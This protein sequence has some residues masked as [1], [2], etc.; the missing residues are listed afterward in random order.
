MKKASFLLVLLLYG[1]NVF[2]DCI[3]AISFWPSGQSIKQNSIILIE[4][5]GQS[6]E[7]VQALNKKYPVYLKTGNKKV[8]L[9]VREI[10]VG[11][12]NLTQAVLTVNEQLIIGQEY[13]LFIDGLPEFATP[14]TR[15]NSATKKN[16]VVK[17]IVEKNS[18]VEK[19][20]WIAKPSEIRKTLFFW[21]CGPEAN[22][23]FKFEITD[24]SEF[25]IKTTVSNIE[26]KKSTTCYV[27]PSDSSTFAVGRDMC[28]GAFT[29]DGIGN[30]EATFDIVDA[31]GNITVW[32]DRKIVFT[33]P[34]ETTT[35]D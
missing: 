4:G 2:A 19:P 13:E 12:Y 35:E 30:F 16:D 17:W 24:K 9:K 8:K 3:S 6:R 7:I 21:G 27:I 11:E 1:A 26:T 29:F 5:F 31:S 22:I 23:H 32:T 18:D 25:L 15:W 20:A 10:L 34:T 33:K 28:S 14:L